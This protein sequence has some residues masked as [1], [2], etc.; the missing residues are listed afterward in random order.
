[1]SIGLR[2][3]TLKSPISIRWGPHTLSINAFIDVQS[4]I[5]E[6]IYE[7]TCTNP[8]KTNKGC[9]VKNWTTFKGYISMKI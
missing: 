7:I 8:H 6:D 1:M 9:M 3:S 2:K 4:K 5:P